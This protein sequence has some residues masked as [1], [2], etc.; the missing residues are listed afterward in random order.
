[1]KKV[2]KKVVKETTKDKSTKTTITVR[3]SKCGCDNFECLHK[4]GEQKNLTKNE[5]GT[6]IV[7]KEKSF[8]EKDK[9][10]TLKMN[11][12]VTP[13]VGDNGTNIIRAE[14]TIIEEIVFKKQSTQSNIAS[15]L[16]NIMQ[17]KQPTANDINE[18]M[19]AV[20][21]GKKLP[22]N[23]KVMAVGRHNTPFPTFQEFL[24]MIRKE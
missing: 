14:E 18:L 11:L 22:D 8:T 24:E 7:T 17:S 2:S 6:Y 5:D 20:L 21:S 19:K 23:V 13:I 4:M 16:D 10:V 9:V 3:E 15:I 12:L 1:M